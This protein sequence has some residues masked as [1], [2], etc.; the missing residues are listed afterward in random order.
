VLY[1]TP[2]QLAAALAPCPVDR[3]R[4]TRARGIEADFPGWEVRHGLYGWTGRRASDGRMVSSTSAPG[5][6]ALLG[7]MTA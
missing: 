7:V 1:G 3:A 5:L 4:D 6:L 2:R